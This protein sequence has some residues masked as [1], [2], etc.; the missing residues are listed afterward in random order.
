[1]S[2]LLHLVNTE[3]GESVWIGQRSGDSGWGIYTDN[4]GDV[5]SF[6]LDNI[7]KPLRVMNDHEIDDAQARGTL[8]Y[9]DDY[10]K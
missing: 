6:L 7:G 8:P 3:T 2:T 10:P 1:M 9:F 4:H 5:A